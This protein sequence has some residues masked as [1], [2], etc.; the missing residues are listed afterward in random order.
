M[1]IFKFLLCFVPMLFL[2]CEELS[3]ILSDKSV[4]YFEGKPEYLAVHKTLPAYTASILTNTGWTKM[5]L[6]CVLPERFAVQTGA[7]DRAQIIMENHGVLDVYPGSLIVVNGPEIQNVTVLQGKCAFVPLA[8][9]LL[10]TWVSLRYDEER[11]EF[12]ENAKQLYLEEKNG[13]YFAKNPFSIATSFSS[14]TVPKGRSFSIMVD[15]NRLLDFSNFKLDRLQP[16][17][18]LISSNSEPVESYRYMAVTGIDIYENTDNLHFNSEARDRHGN[19]IKMR[20]Y[21]PAEAWRYSVLTGSKL[22]YPGSA[23]DEASLVFQKRF[24]AELE[25]KMKDPVFKREY[26]TKF[27]QQNRQI[28][29][30]WKS[31]QVMQ[32]SAVTRSFEPVY[33]RIFSTVSPDKYWQGNFIIPVS[34]VVT[35][36]FGHY[37]YYYGGHSSTHRGIDIANTVGTGVHAPNAGKIVFAGH[38]PD[39]GNNIVIDHGL[40]VYTCFFHLAEIFVAADDIVQTGDVVASI[41]NTGLS[42]GPHLHWEMVVNGRRVNPLDWTKAAP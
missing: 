21:I 40:G 28:S 4:M 38:T 11:A 34:G 26:Q 31:Q 8:K 15:S 42:T 12:L 32:Q 16:S 6:F 14:Q 22:T 23:N 17:F 30:Y 9:A 33:T 1:R 35:S 25:E 41:G 20:A 2:A 24:R 19:W 37:R 10:E 36:G 5:A 18:T 27:E 3:I 13:M 39:R 29:F 7:D